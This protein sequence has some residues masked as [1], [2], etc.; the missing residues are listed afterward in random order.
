MDAGMR[1]A[2]ALC[3]LVACAFHGTSPDPARPEGIDPKKLYEFACRHALAPMAA[4]AL[5]QGGLTDEEALRAFAEEKARAL[6]R[7][8]LLSSERERVRQALAEA[9]VW[10]APL[11]GEDVARCWPAPEL[12][13]SVD[14]DLLIP[15]EG[16][17]EAAR[18]MEALGYAREGDPEKPTHEMNF[19]KA[20]IYYFELHD[21]LFGGDFCSWDEH[22]APLH[23]RLRE[24]GDLRLR[25]TPEDAYVYFI[26][27]A[28]KHDHYAGIG[29]RFLVDLYALNTRRSDEFDT[30]YVS[31]E[32]AEKLFASPEREPQLTKEEETHLLSM[33]EA[34][35]YGTFSRQ[36]ENELRR[37]AGEKM[38]AGAKLA[39]LWHRAFP[40]RGYFLRTDAACAR[41]PRRIPAARLRRLGNYLRH[42]R[43][44]IAELKT[45]SKTK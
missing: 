19:S 41:D 37:T 27:H 42:P 10:T 4:C 11:K 39:Y 5:E 34:G 26:A 21:A 9:G 1:L 45:V 2:R 31:R 18:V 38:T 15:A 17:R 22:F 25:L 36:V 28:G 35:T 8:V 32:L 16:R 23:D 7:Y 3:Y 13:R 20:P 29:L 33:A 14:V 43:K 40:P 6:R 44:L 30:N 12:R 24:E